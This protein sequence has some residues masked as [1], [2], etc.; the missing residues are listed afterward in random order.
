MRVLKMMFYL[1]LVGVPFSWSLSEWLDDGEIISPFLLP[2]VNEWKSDMDRAGIAYKKEFADI[3][4]INLTEFFIEKAGT[5]SRF[6]H[7]ILIDD[8]LIKHGPLS[9]KATVYHELGHYIFQLEHG[10]CVIMEKT[11]HLESDYSENWNT[12]LKEYLIVCNR[13]LTQP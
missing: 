12:Y 7:M 3:R 4:H 6:N 1:I 11:A 8:S 5:S 10:S 13:S 9:V 2:Y